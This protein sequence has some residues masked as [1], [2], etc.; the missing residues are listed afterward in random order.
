MRVCTAFEQPHKSDSEQI[1]CE[2]VQVTVSVCI[3]LNQIFDGTAGSVQLNM[4]KYVLC[5]VA[6]PGGP[7]L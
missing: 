7:L 3:S 4:R 2:H 5:L 1:T 6:T